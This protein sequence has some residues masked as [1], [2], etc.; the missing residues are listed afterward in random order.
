MKRVLLWA[1]IIVLGILLLVLVVNLPSLDD[2]LLYVQDM[3][4]YQETPARSLD[5]NGRFGFC[6]QFVT[7]RNAQRAQFIEN[8]LDARGI[9]YELLPIGSPSSTGTTFNNIWVPMGDDGPYTIYSAHYDKYYDE[10]DYQGASDNSAA[11]CMLLVAAEELSNNPPTKP[12]AFLFTGEEERGLLGAKSFYEYAAQNNL[13]I[14]E[15]LNF[16]SMGRSG[17]SVRASGSRSGYVFTIPLL[18]EYV[19]DGREFAPSSLYRQPDSDLLKRLQAI[20]PITHYDRMVAN[21]DGTF[22]QEQGWNALNLSSD[23]IYYLDETW[24]RYNDRVELLDENNFDLAV[25]LMV[26]YAKSP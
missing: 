23:D 24:H 2:G 4:A 8:Y 25:D 9:S 26:G 18:G 12:I 1:G 16:D 19:Y 10:P 22:W 7:L 5:E 13:P 14:A 11:V 21:S 6:Y 17:I 20:V 15:I 3:L